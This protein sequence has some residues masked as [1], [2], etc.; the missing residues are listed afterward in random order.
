MKGLVVIIGILALLA[1][2]PITGTNKAYAECQAIAGCAAEDD[3]GPNPL[4]ES[5]TYDPC[6]SWMLWDVYFT[7]TQQLGQTTVRYK[8]INSG[9]SKSY[10]TLV[11]KDPGD[12]HFSGK[13][14]IGLSTNHNVEIRR[15]YGPGGAFTDLSLEV[16]YA[17]DDPTK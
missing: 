9:W 2:M 3:T 7:R 17:A 4:C 12:Y 10:S 13:Q 11:Y 1:S 16:E 8:V 15:T 5:A 14:Y 6:N